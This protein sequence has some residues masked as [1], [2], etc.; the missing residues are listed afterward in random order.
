MIIIKSI[1][2]SILMD[3][4]I[5]QMII[6]L[7]LQFSLCLDI[8][9]LGFQNLR[10]LNFVVR[11]QMRQKLYMLEKFKFIKDFFPSL[12]SSVFAYNFFQTFYIVCWKPLCKSLSIIPKGFSVLDP[13]PY[14]CII[15]ILFV[16]SSE[17]IQ[18]NPKV[19]ESRLDKFEER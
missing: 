18:L 15:L 13:L 12:L 17:P 19:H 11:I 9:I 10:R 4:Y 1:N 8:S 5:S 6:F 16:K 3:S 7:Y 14:I 2:E